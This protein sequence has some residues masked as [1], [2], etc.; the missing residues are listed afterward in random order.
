MGAL[1]ASLTM[2]IRRPVA[3]ILLAAAVAWPALPA[4][5]APR[6]PGAIADVAEQV[7]GAVV[8][9]STKQTVDMSDNAMPQR[10]PGTPVEQFF[11]D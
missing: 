7:I 6:G 4:S 2:P 9:I 3:A 5:A 10:P 11:E 1:F 8:N